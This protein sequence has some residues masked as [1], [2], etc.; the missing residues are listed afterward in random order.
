MLDTNRSPLPDM[1]DALKQVQ[2]FDEKKTD[3][4]KRWQ[5]DDGDGKWYEKSDV[6]GKISKRE[7]KSKS[8]DCASKVKHEEYGV[9]ECMKEMHDLDENGN[10]AHYDVLFSHGIEKNVP[11]ENLEIVKEGVHEHVIHDQ[12]EVITDA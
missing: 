12:D 11:V 9:G 2:Q 6:D 3:K 8:H 7:K 4:P 1:T 10:V 5:D